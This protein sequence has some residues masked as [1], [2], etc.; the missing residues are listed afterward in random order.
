[1]PVQKIEV[2]ASRLPP[3]SASPPE[4]SFDGM[5]A[6]QARLGARQVRLEF[7]DRIDV[8]GLVGRT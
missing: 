5:Q 1:M 2:Q 3:L 4:N 6:V 7:G 8:P